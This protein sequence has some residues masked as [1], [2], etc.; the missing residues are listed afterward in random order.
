MP[1]NVMMLDSMG[2]R[3]M[4][5]YA[6]GLRS[7]G[8][9]P[10]YFVAT[11]DPERPGQY[12]IVP[13]FTPP[14]SP[15][16]D[17]VVVPCDTRAVSE[18]RR[19][20]EIILVYGDGDGDRVSLC[21][22]EYDAVFT[23]ES[24][25]EKFL[26]PYYASKYQWAAASKLHEMSMTWYGHLPDMASGEGDF[27]GIVVEE[28]LPFAMA[29]YPRSDYSFQ[30]PN[31]TDLSPGADVHAFSVSESGQAVREPLSPS[32]RHPAAL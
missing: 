28:A 7:P 2:M 1:D 20:R 3:Q 16:S 19:V 13:S 17:E 15:L 24:A 4:A 5:E 30:D 12:T 22:D 11:E 21:G 14:A 31:L 26:F 6:S 25:V 27:P 18:R 32:R 8:G 29:H 9:D 23:S 10:V